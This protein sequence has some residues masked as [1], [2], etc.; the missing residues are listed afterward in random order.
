MARKDKTDISI[1]L[2]EY[3]RVPRPPQVK[4]A[5]YKCIMLGEPGVGKT[6]LTQRIAH[7]H[8]KHNT[9][10]TFSPS[11]VLRNVLLPS[12]QMISLDI[13]DTAGQERFHSL[14]YSYYRGAK[15]ALILYDADRRPLIG[16]QLTDVAFNFRKYR[17]NEELE[18]LV[19]LVGTKIDLGKNFAFT[20]NEIQSLSRKEGVPI[21]CQ[22][23]LSAKTAENVDDT[24]R[25]LAEVLSRANN[26]QQ[27]TKKE[28][29]RIGWK[30]QETSAKSNK[31][32]SCC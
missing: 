7:D 25:K 16:D 32:W 31:W 24:V 4:Q 5:P 28:V 19:F 6:S 18:T 21:E 17:G 11:S 3:F 15:A 14:T 10:A 1:D 29:I 12:G 2:S 22:F 9:L 30:V 13:W 8:F 27:S 26:R 20:E 23:L